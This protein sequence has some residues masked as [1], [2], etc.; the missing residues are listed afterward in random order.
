MKFIIAIIFAVSAAVVF[1][2][3]SKQPEAQAVLTTPISANVT[4]TPQIG[5]IGGIIGGIGGI[6]SGRTSPQPVPTTSSP[7]NQTTAFP[8]NLTSPGVPS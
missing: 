6:I 8:Q 5:G 2:Q 3:T 7:F 4:K 1:S